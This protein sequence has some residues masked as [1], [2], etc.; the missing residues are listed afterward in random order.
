MSELVGEQ[1]SHVE[2]QGEREGRLSKHV[3]RAA[4]TAVLEDSRT[5]I[6]GPLSGCSP[7]HTL[8]THTAGL[9]QNSGSQNVFLP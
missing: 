6:D 5:P 9:F 1:R 4:E 2:H 8:V 7:V 3:R